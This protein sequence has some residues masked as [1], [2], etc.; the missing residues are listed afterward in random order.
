[1][2]VFPKKIPQKFPRNIGNFKEVQPYC[3]DYLKRKKKVQ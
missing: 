3:C 1:M 2:T